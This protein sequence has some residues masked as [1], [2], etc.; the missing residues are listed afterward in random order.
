[1][2]NL[3]T[4]DFEQLDKPVYRGI[5]FSGGDPLHEKN[6]DEV[7]DFLVEERIERKNSTKERNI[8]L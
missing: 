7:T 8:W 2:T 6:V 5:T 1:M 4:G 3:Q